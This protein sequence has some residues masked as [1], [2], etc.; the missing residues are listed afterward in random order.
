M[1][2]RGGSMKSN[3]NGHGAN[4]NERAFVPNLAFGSNQ[5]AEYHDPEYFSEDASKKV[6]TKLVYGPRAQE[7]VFRHK[8]SVF[9]TDGLRLVAGASTGMQFTGAAASAA[10]ILVPFHGSTRITCDSETVEW[11]QGKNALLVPPAPFSG[12]ASTRSVVGIEIQPGRLSDMARSMLLDQK[13]AERDVML[14]SNRFRSL[15]LHIGRIQ[16]DVVF[17][18]YMAMIDALNGDIGLVGRAGVDDM[19]VRTAVMLL[20]PE[21]F[22]AQPSLPSVKRS[23]LHTVC[24]YIEANLD[25]KLTLSV[26]ETVSG[27]STRGL[28]YAFASTFG[29]SPMQWVRVRRVEAVRRLL[30]AAHAGENVTAIASRYFVNLGEFSRLYRE[31]FGELPS[32]TLQ[33]ALR[34]PL[35]S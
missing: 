6:G 35:R 34:K 5:A 1:I 28:Q 33:T 29:M 7:R 9:H 32:Q 23:N 27:L 22:I 20:A 26:L 12:E 21:L 24:D 14:D 25:Q 15:D 8:V 19:I 18:Q 17:A 2:N 11:Q 13:A 16:F 4:G 10:F 3:A 31:R 30:L